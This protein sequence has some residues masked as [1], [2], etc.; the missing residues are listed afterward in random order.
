MKWPRGKYNGLRVGGLKVKVEV[1]VL[2]W[3]WPKWEL[4]G[5][6]P[7]IHVGPIHIWWEKAFEK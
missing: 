5:W 6:C 3:N 1:N 2:W 7:Y 4:I